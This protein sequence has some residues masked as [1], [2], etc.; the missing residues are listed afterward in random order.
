MNCDVQQNNVM[1]TFI[2][3]HFHRFS[4]H[5]VHTITVNQFQQIYIQPSIHATCNSHLFPSFML[6]LIIFLPL[7]DPTRMMLGILLLPFLR[8]HLLLH[9][10]R[11]RNIQSSLHCLPFINPIRPFLEFSC[12]NVSP[13][14]QNLTYAFTTYGNDS[15]SIPAHSAQ[16]THEKHA[17]SAIVN[18]SPTIQGPSPLPIPASPPAVEALVPA[19]VWFADFCSTS[20]SSRTWYR[21]LV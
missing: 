5:Y 16:F 14:P 19:A 4:I 13:S 17:I 11:L 10:E 20:L 9:L 6:L 21:R 18:L 12:F 2:L 8:L 7:H 15:R 1:Y 3:G